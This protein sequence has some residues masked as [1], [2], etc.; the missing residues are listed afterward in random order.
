MLY[1]EIKV[2]TLIIPRQLTLSNI[3]CIN[4]M[5]IKVITLIIPRQLTLS[6]IV[7]INMNVESALQIY[8]ILK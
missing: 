2:I 3:V 5:E 8:L 1:M 7:C 4:N 6:N